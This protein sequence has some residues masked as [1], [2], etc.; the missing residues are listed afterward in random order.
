MQRQKL[1]EKLLEIGKQA[2]SESNKRRMKTTLP[3]IGKVKTHDT[4]EEIAE[5]LGW[6]H[7]KV[8]Q[9]DIVSNNATAETK[10]K[11]LEIGKETQGQR[12]DLLP[13]IGKK[14]PHNTKLLMN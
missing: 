2:I 7:G 9:A 6:S 4:R 12:T 11:L 1:K 14:S 13:I 10:E 5:E 3:T 8:S